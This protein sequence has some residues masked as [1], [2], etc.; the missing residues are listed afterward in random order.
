RYSPSGAFDFPEYC[1][2]VLDD[3]DGFSLEETDTELEAPAPS[4]LEELELS[5]AA[6]AGFAPS[7]QA[8]NSTANPEMLKVPIRAR[9]DKPGVRVF[10]GEHIL[11]KIV[12]G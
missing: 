1:G 10:I 6:P 12:A 8:D 2:D 3:G 9:R 7:P 11:K 4:A 5:T